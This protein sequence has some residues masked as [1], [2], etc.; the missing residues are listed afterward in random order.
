MDHWRRSAALGH[1]IAMNT[2][3][4]ALTD[5]SAHGGVDMNAGLAL[6]KEASDKGNSIATIHLAL[7]YLRG[8]GV[9]IRYQSFGK[10]MQGW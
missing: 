1:T 8:Y 6:F 10:G 2:T 9:K 4:M 7:F 5:G 3:A